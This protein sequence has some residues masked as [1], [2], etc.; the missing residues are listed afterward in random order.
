MSPGVAITGNPSL[1]ISDLFDRIE[2]GKLG[3]NTT[4]CRCAGTGNSQW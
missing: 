1:I 3:G 4:I 2:M